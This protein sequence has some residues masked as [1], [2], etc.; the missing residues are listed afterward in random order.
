MEK[1]N[2]TKTIFKKNQDMCINKP[3]VCGG[4]KHCL[5]TTRTFNQTDPNCKKC[6][7]DVYASMTQ[8]H[9]TKGDVKQ[10]IS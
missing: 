4:Y 6:L 2:N 7:K 10:W 8:S 9:Q 5:A 1:I 3:E